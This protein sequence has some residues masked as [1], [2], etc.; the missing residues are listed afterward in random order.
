MLEIP[1]A[2]G[3]RIH[4]REPLTHN[5]GNAATGGIWRVRGDFGS[6]VV[7]IARPPSVEPVGTIYWQTSDDPRHWNYWRREVLSYGSALAS[8][9][10]DDGDI[11]A[12]VVRALRERSDG[13]YELWLGDEA[14]APGFTWPVARIGA[15]A[16]HLGLAQAGWAGR[17]PDL[18]WLSRG[19]LRQY[20]A[21]GPSRSA[22]ESDDAAW[23]SPLLEEWPAQT[24][25]QLRRLWDQRE[26][27][28]TRAE[29]L[30][31]TLCH[32]DVWPNNLVAAG[33]RSVLLDWSFVGDGAI[34]EDIANLIIDSF[35]DGLMDV[36]K[37]PEVVEAASDGYIDGLRDG[38]W[39]GPPDLARAGIVICA[40]AKYSWFA[41]ATAARVASGSFGHAQ[42]GRDTDAAAAVRRLRDLVTLLGEWADAALS[43]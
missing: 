15:F 13:S 19:W 39:D 9:A 29:E 28:V 3:G 2:L 7:K 43:G 6:A 22:V 33:D 20:L 11:S 40:V 24:R 4:H 17:V 1:A 10:F 14:G 16:Y 26:V 38:G 25:A 23:S 35:T 41:P 31:R 32:L 36:A 12:P 5:K 37:L 8:T 42:Y 27:L 30:P 18:P 21:N 34:G